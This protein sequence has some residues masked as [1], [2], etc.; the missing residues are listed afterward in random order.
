MSEPRVSIVI[1][2]YEEGDA[3]LP[4]LH[5]IQRDVEIEY[6]VIV[7]VDDESD[8]TIPVVQAFQAEDARYRHEV[9]NLGRGPAN[10][11]RTGFDRACAPVIVVTMA[12]GSDDA[13]IIEDMVCLVERG[14]AIA[15]AS[16]YMP[17]GAQV[18]GPFL[19]GLMSKSAGR[20][21]YWFARTGTH[22]ATN[23]FKAYSADF[24][25]RVGI[26]SRDGFEIGIELVAKAKRRRLPVAELPTIWLDRDAGESNF[27]MSRWLP[28][29]LHWYKHAFGPSIPYETHQQ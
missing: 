25:N 23:S 24:V 14:C 4:V 1:P 20:S 28:K 27:Q 10:A 26:E 18:G 13:R 2:A 17:G 29:Y 22:D 3:V 5:R 7:V 8:S 12:D 11:I 9:N 21:L 19:K 15:A 6:E 16:R